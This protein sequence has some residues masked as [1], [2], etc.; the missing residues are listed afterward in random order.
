MLDNPP[1][2]KVRKPIMRPTEKQ[3]LAFADAITINVADCMDGRG[4]MHHFIKSLQRILQPFAG[5][6]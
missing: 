6:H 1:I 3:I 5:Q 2:L 4:A